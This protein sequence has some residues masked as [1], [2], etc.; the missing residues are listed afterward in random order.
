MLSGMVQSSI[1]FLALNVTFF[2]CSKILYP[3]FFFFQSSLQFPRSCDVETQMNRYL[4]CRTPSKC[5][6][7]MPFVLLL[8]KGGIALVLFL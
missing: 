2:N 6:L 4:C 8:R 7:R 3:V 1:I 5:K